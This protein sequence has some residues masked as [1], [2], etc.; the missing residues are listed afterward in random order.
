MNSIRAIIGA[1]IVALTIA[2]CA[3][4]PGSGSGTG[5]SSAFGARPP[6][7]NADLFSRLES[8]NENTRKS[9]VKDV[10][11]IGTPLVPELLRRL[12]GLDSRAAYAAAIALGVIKDR[13]AVEPMI[14]TLSRSPSF[15]VRYAAIWAL[16]R[17]DDRRA[18][19]ILKRYALKGDP[20]S[21]VSHLV[22][23]RA[24]QSLQ[25]V[26]E[27]AGVEAWVRTYRDKV[28]NVSWRAPSFIGYVR[29][30]RAT[31]A[32]IK[33]FE[34]GSPK[35]RKGVLSALK[36]IDDPRRLDIFI[37]ATGD[38]DVDVRVAAVQALGRMGNRRAVPTLN[39][40]LKD[41]YNI[42]RYHSVIAL[43]E[44]GDRRSVKHIMYGLGGLLNVSRKMR[45]A[46]YRNLARIGGPEAFD[47]VM[48]RLEGLLAFQQADLDLVSPGIRHA[49][50]LAFRELPS[51]ISN[52]GEIG[53]PRAL[54][55][56][57]R[58]LDHE[59]KTI[60]ESAAKAIAKL[61]LRPL[62]V[63]LLAA[64]RRG[65]D[66]AI[67]AAFAAPE[68]SGLAD[69]L[70]LYALL[71]KPDGPAREAAGQ[72]LARAGAFSVLDAPPISAEARKAFA[73]GVKE[74]RK[75]SPNASS[76]RYYSKMAVELAP[77]W[78]EARY[79]LALVREMWDDRSGA[80]ENF[81][82]YLTL[83]PEAHNAETVRR[84]IAR[85]KQPRKRQ[86]RGSVPDFTG[87]EEM[88]EAIPP[89]SQLPKIRKPSI[90]LPPAP[91]IRA[92]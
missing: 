75:P 65:D 91:D 15:G 5:P 74:F 30:P 64:V 16:G 4:A 7:R 1:C 78:A 85:L 53:D 58:F 8:S 33:A 12:A 57:M 56:L 92:P 49:V 68:R 42:V 14:W 66:K 10:R 39:A 80:V 20:R 40:L 82:F 76:S 69:V 32:L 62:L 46:A 23:F 43:G 18:A 83:A 27:A 28:E 87:P 29:D 70:A 36:W 86:T 63:D 52:L 88:M 13:R 90:P 31:G 77:W 2:G 35:I 45:N 19:P 61:D 50:M 73:A 72:A 6:S 41:Q 26:D 84:R 47:A 17:F 24:L 89:R 51:M 3:P 55:P 79:N 37:R 67:A 60:R 59:D 34:D 54:K 22:R 25:A 81:E 44:L 21:R 11:R 71:E 38:R 48:R 9:A